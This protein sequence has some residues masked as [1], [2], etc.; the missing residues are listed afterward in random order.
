MNWWG[1]QSQPKVRDLNDLQ[2]LVNW[3]Q[4]KELKELWKLT[5][6]ASL[7]TLWLSKNEDIF[8]N[9]GRKT[10]YTTKFIN[11]KAKEWVLALELILPRKLIYMESLPTRSCVEKSLH[12]EKQAID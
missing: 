10:H 2:E 5:P 11:F 4:K 1:I 6:T 9:K 12:K 8:I 3:Y 7:W